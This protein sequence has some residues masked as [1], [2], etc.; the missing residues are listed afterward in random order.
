MSADPFVSSVQRS[1][2]PRR[3]AI[4]TVV[5][6]ALLLLGGIAFGAFA[7]QERG[8]V[9]AATVVAG[10]EVGGLD[11]DEARRRIRAAARKRLDDPVRLVTLGSETEVSG[12]ALRA[13]PQLDQALAQ[14]T[15]VSVVGRLARRLGL[16]ETRRIPLRYR[17]DPERIEVLYRELQGRFE[18][19]PRSAR[20]VVEASGVRVVP[21]L[22]GTTVDEIAFVRGLKRLP[23]SFDVP[24]VDVE[25]E[26]TTAAAERAKR[27]ASRLLSEPRTVRFP[28][29]DAVLRPA[30][31]RNALRFEPTA[32]GTLAM[33]LDPAVLRAALAS[34]L[35]GVETPP[36]DARFRVEGERVVVVPAKP[37]RGLDEAALAA[38]LARNLGSTIHRARFAVTQPALTTAAAQNLQIRELVAEFTTYYSC[39]QPRVSNIQRA[40]EL[41]DGT[42]VRPG[43]TFSMNEALGRRT[44]ERGFVAAPQ[45]FRGRLEDAVGGGI[46]QVATTLY[47]AAFFAGVKLVEHQ[48]HQFYISR[49]PMGREATVSWGG[50]E[51]VFRNDWPAGILMKLDASDTAIRVRFYSSRLGRRVVTVTGEPYAYRAPSTITIRNP[52]LAPGATS[53]VQSAGAS[54][55]TVQ[56]TRKVFKGARL[57]KDESYTVR[58]DPQNA[59][60]EVGPPKPKPKPTPKPKPVA[61]EQ[62]PGDGA[63]PPP[64][65][66]SSGANAVET[67]GGQTRPAGPDP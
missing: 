61:G 11:E 59:I 35:R 17:A 3:V 43:E 45:I 32:R 30:A 47:N 67:G 9:P 40:A 33:R 64:A 2:W 52:S 16:G 63:S 14:A 49:Y 19:Q 21:A 1:P 50:P 51:L 8:R 58:Y 7:W 62:P 13:T 18:R 66:D 12:A 53:V 6:G 36:V 29:R 26:V 42:I 4:A 65:P 28:E 23:R 10:V 31:L 20:L 56:Y 22:V 60:V 55:F 39:C 57:L 27:R 25:P 48:A 5:L 41:L 38:S 44:E 54:G 46:S 34:A 37:G 24:L 15:D